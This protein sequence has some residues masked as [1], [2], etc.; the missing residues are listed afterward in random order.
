MLEP[1]LGM[2]RLAQKNRASCVCV[3]KEKRCWE[4]EVVTGADRDAKLPYTPFR[5]SPSEGSV[6]FRSRGGLC[7]GSFVM[8]SRSLESAMSTMRKKSFSKP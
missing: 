1:L 4:L 2:A 7:V 6:H 3:S 8:S 5:Q